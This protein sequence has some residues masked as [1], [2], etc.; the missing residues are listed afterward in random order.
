MTDNNLSVQQKITSYINTHQQLQGKPLSEV[1]SVMIED[2][3][4]TAAELEE[5]QKTS[6]F[7]TGKETKKTDSVV[8][9]HPQTPVSG[10][11]AATALKARIEAVANNL[12]TTKDQN[13]IVG[14]LWGG[15]KNLVGIGDSSNKVNDAMQEELKL[16]ENGNIDIQKDFEKLTGEKYTPENFAKFQSGE[17]KLK[18]EQALDKYKEGQDMAVDIAGDLTS[19]F[20]AF[21]AYTLSIALA[22]VTG[23]ASIAIGIG[24]AAA[25]GAAIKSATKFVDAKSGGREYDSFGRDLATGAFSGV[26][27]PVTGGLGGAA[28]KTAAKAMGLQAVKQVGKEVAEEGA[29]S[30]IK[31]GAKSILMNPTGYKYVGE[32]AVK[33][34]IAYGTEMATGGAVAGGVDNGFRTAYDGGDIGDVAAAAGEGALGGLILSPILG[35][36]IKYLGHKV[37]GAQNRVRTNYEK[38]KLASQNNPVVENPDAD[39]AK[40]L[41]DTF[42]QAEE[43][44]KGSTEKGK[45]IAG[46][47]SSKLET[48]SDDVS[49]ILNDTKTL[50]TELK[51]ISEENLVAIKQILEDYAHG[52]D[53]SESLSKL[54][55]RG[56]SITDMLDERIG[57][58][59]EQLQNHIEHYQHVNNALGPNIAEGGQ[60]V[61]ETLDS[62]SALAQRAI[63]EGKKIPETSAFKLLGNLPDRASKAYKSLRTE[64]VKLDKVAEGAKKKIAA[65]DIEGGL[66][67]LQQYYQGVEVLNKDLEKEVT[68][69]SSSAAR[70]GLDESI[71][72]LSER[73]NKLMSSEG[74]SKLKPEEQLEAITENANILFA[75]FAQTFSSD[76]NLPK[77]LTNV[78]KQFTSKCSVSRTMDQAQTLADELYGAGKYKITDSFGAGTIGETY[79][80][81]TADG[82][83][84]VIK[85]LK[86]GVTPEKFKQDREMFTKYINEFTGDA[87]DKEYKTN[88]INNMFDAW[89]RE[90]NFGLEAQG[91]KNMADGAERFRVAQTLEV[92]AKDGRNISLV[93]EKAPGIAL[94]KLLEMLQLYKQN[95]S[96]YLTKY[97]KK[98]EEYPVLK[99]PSKWMGDVSVAYQAAQ[100]EQVMFVNKSGSRTIHGDPHAGNIFVDFNAKTGKPEIVYIDTGNVITKT[101]KEMIKDLALSMDM[102]F[103]HSKGIADAVLEGATIPTGTTKEELSAKIAKML[104]ERMFKANVN[105]KNTQFSQNTVSEILKELNVIP[106]SNN[107]NLLKATLQRVETARAIK[108]VCG[109]NG[110]DKIL[111]IKDMGIALIKAFRT[112]PK[113]TWDAIKPIIQWAI[114]NK[115][116]AMVT[117]FQM[118]IKNAQVQQQ[119]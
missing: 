19:G 30:T 109:F 34:G 28:G 86:D 44:L 83:E 1:I 100:N 63:D 90:L 39:L 96:E 33:K 38:A 57:G 41:S 43:L 82:K 103:G 10:A 95:P 40:A 56:I 42:K 37:G 46:S 25:S 116:Q 84:V 59:S 69:M 9:N 87:A 88:L 24:A 75:K 27:A 99:D 92:G 60:L 89:D 53:V 108:N 3:E 51:N 76:K 74:F 17:L 29:K 97:A 20:A 61:G 73:M 45:K 114:N 110:N 52:E 36:G 91:A 115:D 62:A 47:A 55:Q 117:F 67:D 23:G 70:A 50:N 106:D 11:Q 32:S 13:G 58:I 79:L 4:I 102:M 112:N 21:G 12:K 81:K 49:V 104:D 7:D 22:P 2:G 65:G 105:L 15:L 14:T 113:E 48:L 35:G 18:C 107:S 94:D 78:L 118:I 72:I 16:L 66:K 8:I 64:S 5:L 101:N 80:A 85:M 93:M 119:A 77:E 26:L 111:N 68:S 31:Q 71:Q 98:I 6:M 54:A